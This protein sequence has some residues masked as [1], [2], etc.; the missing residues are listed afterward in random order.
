MPIEVSWT[1]N[2][3]FK[4][5][6]FYLNLTLAQLE[7][8]FTLR[9]IIWAST[10]ELER[11]P[12]PTRRPGSEEKFSLNA[13]YQ[14]GSNFGKGRK[15]LGWLHR[16]KKGRHAQNKSK[17]QA[18]FS[19]KRDKGQYPKIAKKYFFY[20]VSFVNLSTIVKYSQVLARPRSV[21]NFL[22]W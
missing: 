22:Y 18:G 13:Q 6:T 16:A 3:G 19:I 8:T 10:A 11:V 21:R 2:Y 12:G 20:E 15:R 4:L 14:P 1:Q 9:Q 5:V 7:I 17:A